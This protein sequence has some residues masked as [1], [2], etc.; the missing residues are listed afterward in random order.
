MPANYGASGTIVG[1]TPTQQ[2]RFAFT[3]KGVDQKRQSVEQAYGIRVGPPLPLT[4]TTVSPLAAGT[5]GT[6]YAANFFLWRRATV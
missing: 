6:S 1:G 2:G 5:L 3:V 4:D